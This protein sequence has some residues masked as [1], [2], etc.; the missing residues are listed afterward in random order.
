MT[1]QRVTAA[2]MAEAL[3]QD[4]ETPGLTCRTCGCRHFIVV[5]TRP[6]PGGILRRRQCRNCG[7]RITTRERGG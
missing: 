2:Q 4:E 7:R 3:N 1:R 5:Y 6:I